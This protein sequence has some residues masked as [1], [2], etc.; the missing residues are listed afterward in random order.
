[1]WHLQD[2]RGPFD[3]RAFTD[4]RARI[5]CAC[6]TE[7]ATIEL[8][9]FESLVPTPWKNGEGV[10]RQI[11]TYPSGASLD[12]F[13]WRISV[14]D[15]RGSSPFSV[16][17][18][19]DRTIVLLEGEGLYLETV[20]GITRQLTTPFVPMQFSG[21]ERIHAHL[22]GGHLSRDFN[23]MVRREAAEAE[24]EITRSAGS[25][26]SDGDFVL[27]FCA[28]G[29]WELQCDGATHQLSSK[30]TLVGTLRRR[31]DLAIK[32]LEEDSVLLSVKAR[33]RT[34][35]EHHLVGSKTIS[36]NVS[37]LYSSSR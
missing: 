37:G 35:K 23:L 13:H 33:S 21:E 14:A 32:P 26:S 9:D 25:I 2:R 4:S 12:E 36:L 16:F 29:Q 22:A 20:E 18:G 17:P 1:M 27:L 3:A 31:E 19:V 30:Q 10:T 28:T 11:A 15:V 5:S 6:G 34:W 24:L 8:F 7:G